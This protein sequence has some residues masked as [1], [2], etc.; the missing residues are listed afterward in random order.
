M[1]Y[2]NLF[3]VLMGLGIVFIG[4]ICLI[5]LTNLLS[6]LCGK[7]KAAP[8]AVPAP[9]QTAP[10]PNRTELIAAVSAAL[11]EELGTDITGLRILSFKKL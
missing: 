8:A 3:V 2:S 5:L 1:E 9:I 6:A 11:A 4:L 10:E 7:E